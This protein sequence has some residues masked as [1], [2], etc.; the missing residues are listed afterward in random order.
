MAASIHRIHIR[1]ECLSMH[2]PDAGYSKLTLNGL[3][4]FKISRL[5]AFW[6]TL[7]LQ[8]GND[9]IEIK[10]IHTNQ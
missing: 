9:T 4:A 2:W 6:Y 7:S 10:G 3:L 1:D 8:N 5:V